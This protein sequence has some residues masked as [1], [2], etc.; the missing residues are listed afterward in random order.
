MKLKAN[1]TLLDRAYSNLTSFFYGKKLRH[2]NDFQNQNF[3]VL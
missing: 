2:F 1:Q 3:S